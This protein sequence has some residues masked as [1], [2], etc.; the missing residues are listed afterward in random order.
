[1]NLNKACFLI[2]SIQINVLSILIC[3]C[4]TAFLFGQQAQVYDGDYLL[5]GQLE[6]EAVYQYKIE[7]G[8]QIKDGPFEFSSLSDQQEFKEKYLLKG[9]YYQNKKDGK[10]KFSHYLLKA[11]ADE[12][13]VDYSIQTTSSGKVHYV[14]GKVLLCQI[15]SIHFPDEENAI[16]NIKPISQVAFVS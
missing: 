14:E 15:A 4:S 7:K 10:W 1:M 12:F 13:I 3:F 16:K 11:D 8:L 5:S 2:A 9:S 6:G